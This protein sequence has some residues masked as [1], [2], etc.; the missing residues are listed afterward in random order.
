MNIFKAGDRVRRI[1]YNNGDHMPVGFLGT[2]LAKGI[3]AQIE[4][5]RVFVQPDG[6]PQM[7]LY[8]SLKNLELVQPESLS[9]TVT[10]TEYEAWCNAYPYSGVERITWLLNMARTLEA[11]NKGLQETT[12][13][14]Y[15]VIKQQQAKA[16]ELN[17]KGGEKVHLAITSRDARIKE[18]EGYVNTGRIAFQRS[19]EKVEYFR[20]DRDELANRLCQI[21][22]LTRGEQ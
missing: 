21:V 2:V 20:K 10:E 12:N 7:E 16:N 17:S 13:N 14:M 11:K 4:N 6:Q 3:A 15:S 5:S 18:L 22:R 19:Q 1:G 9:K 8:S